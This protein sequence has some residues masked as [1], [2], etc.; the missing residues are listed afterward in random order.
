VRGRRRMLDI[1]QSDETLA[2]F[3]ATIKD[4]TAYSVEPLDVVCELGD[5]DAFVDQYQSEL[6]PQAK[7]S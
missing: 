1:V 4:G 5:V 2:Q 6:A 3:K 7:P